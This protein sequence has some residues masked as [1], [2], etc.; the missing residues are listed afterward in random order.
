[1]Q[2]EQKSRLAFK[3][4]KKSLRKKLEFV[5]AVFRKHT[6]HLIIVLLVVDCSN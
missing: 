5:L 3:A 6:A 4:K 1:M 2:E